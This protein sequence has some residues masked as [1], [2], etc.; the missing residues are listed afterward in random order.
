M[1]FPT[2]IITACLIL[3]VFA[4]TMLAFADNQIKYGDD[5]LYKRLSI[6]GQENGKGL[7][8]KRIKEIMSMHRGGP[9][10]N[11]DSVR[12]MDIEWLF[13]DS[14]LAAAAIFHGAEKYGERIF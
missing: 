13:L 7:T 12:V 11:L 10:I 2:V 6:R 3:L 5:L 9:I 8:D 1:R 4:I 14:N